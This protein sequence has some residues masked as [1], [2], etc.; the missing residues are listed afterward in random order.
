M[1]GTGTNQREYETC[2]CDCAGCREQGNHCCNS[3]KAC[4][5]V[6]RVRRKRYS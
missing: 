3:A 5:F 1:P 2:S 4:N 6:R